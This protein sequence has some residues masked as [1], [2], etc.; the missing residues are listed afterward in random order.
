[1]INIICHLTKKV[2]TKVV[3]N[4]SA[5]TVANFVEDLLNDLGIDVNNLYKWTIFLRSDNGT[6]FVNK[7][8]EELCAKYNVVMKQG[9]VYSPWV[10]G[11]VEK[12]NKTIKDK[13]KI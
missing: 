9:P 13:L 4:K 5:N 1:M 12:V 10:Q 8:M 11:V 2:W 6:E 7:R 3:R